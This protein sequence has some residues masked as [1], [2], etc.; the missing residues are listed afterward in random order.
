MDEEQKYTYY[1]YDW[2][3]ELQLDY[4]FTAPFLRACGQGGCKEKA[5]FCVLGRIR[6]PPFANPGRRA[7]AR[8]RLGCHADGRE[9]GNRPAKPAHVP[10]ML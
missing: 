7:L 4:S 1:G 10:H 8:R 2:Q 9:Q 5:V 6:P 3:G